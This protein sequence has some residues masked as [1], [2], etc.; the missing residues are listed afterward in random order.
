MAREKM[1]TRT[2]TQTTAE[3]MTIDVTSAEVQIREYTIG[4][5]YDTNELLLKKLQKLFQTDTFKLVNINSTTVEDLLL[6]MTEEDLSDTLQ[7]FRLEVL[8]KKVRRVRMITSN[9]VHIIVE[10]K[11]FD[12][13]RFVTDSFSLDSGV[14]IIKQD[15]G[16]RTLRLDYIKSIYIF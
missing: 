4:G 1:V 2:V 9:R 12:A 16:K 15:Y 14:L 7:F 3:V 5:T 13:E 6:G 10:F 11:D 8:K